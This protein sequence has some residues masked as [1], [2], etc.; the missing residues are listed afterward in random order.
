[1]TKAETAGLIALSLLVTGII[2]AVMI[3]EK[4]VPGQEN[5]RTSKGAINNPGNIIKSATVYDGEIDSPSCCMKSFKSMAYGYRAMIKILRNY[6][7]SKGLTDLYSIIKLYSG[8]ENTANYADFVAAGAGID[9]FT[10]LKDI[11]DT[12]TIKDIIMSMSLW[13]QGPNEFVVN[14]AWVNEGYNLA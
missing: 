10:D 7:H 4:N 1:M 6:Y 12:D 9:Q 3:K 5:I 2:I 11:I 14:E 8:D 13:E